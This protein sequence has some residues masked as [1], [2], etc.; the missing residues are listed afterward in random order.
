MTV[1]T[2][3]RRITQVLLAIAALGMLALAISRAVTFIAIDSCL[4]DSGRWNNEKQL[5]E[6]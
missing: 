6:K 5:C 3:L 4:D 1:H 2:K